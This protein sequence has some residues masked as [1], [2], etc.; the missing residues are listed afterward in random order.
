[1]QTNDINQYA[2]LLSEWDELKNNHL[3]TITEMLSKKELQKDS[4]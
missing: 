3:K 1:M 2:K 4:C